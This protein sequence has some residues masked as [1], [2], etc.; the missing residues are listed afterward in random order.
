MFQASWALIF[1]MPQSCEKRRIVGYRVILAQ[2]VLLVC[3]YISVVRE[4]LFHGIERT[5]YAADQFL[6]FQSQSADDLEIDAPAGQQARGL[7]ELSDP[8]QV[9]SVELDDPVVD[10]GLAVDRRAVWRRWKE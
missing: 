8:A 2:G 3:G 5:A 1:V 7:S 10:V 6:S 9:I 4:P